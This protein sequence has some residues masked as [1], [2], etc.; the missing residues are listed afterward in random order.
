M[1]YPPS[2]GVRVPP[3]LKD[4]LKRAAVA[5]VRSLASL[6]EKILTD[7]ATEHAGYRSPAAVDRKKGHA[8]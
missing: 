6:V 2:L 1:R 5:D 3:E 8:D 4:A 7:W